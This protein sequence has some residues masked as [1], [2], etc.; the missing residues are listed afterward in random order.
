MGK[1]HC[2][3]R[4]ASAGFSGGSVPG[5]EEPATETADL[6]DP[7]DAVSEEGA[8]DSPGGPVTE[9]LCEAFIAALPADG[10]SVANSRLRQALGWEESRYDAVR[11]HLVDRRRIQKGRGRGGTVNLVL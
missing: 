8:L 9:D 7:V 1:T 11:N 3:A 4:G 6:D 2:L 5:G 10:T